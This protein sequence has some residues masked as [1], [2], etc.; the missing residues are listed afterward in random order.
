MRWA[1]HVA[2]TGEMRNIL[3]YVLGEHQE[4]RQIR[5]ISIK[6]R[7]TLKS[8]LNKYGARVLIGLIW[9]GIWSSDELL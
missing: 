6:G 5:D 2:H 3:K 4:K 8:I 1:E 9:L 7:L